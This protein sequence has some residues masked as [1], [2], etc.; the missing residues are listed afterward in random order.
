[1]VQS[2]A[3]GIALFGTGTGVHV[4]TLLRRGRAEAGLAVLA[5]VFIVAFAY[6]GT[7]RVTN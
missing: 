5:T 3:I 4:P 1:M 2:I 7:L 6:A